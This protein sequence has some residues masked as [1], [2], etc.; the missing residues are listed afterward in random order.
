MDDNIDVVHE[1]EECPKGHNSNLTGIELLR[2]IV[3]DASSI[4]EV[5]DAQ[6]KLSIAFDA[7]K[8]TDK[9]DR[10]DECNKL[11]SI[12]EDKIRA[13]TSGMEKIEDTFEGTII[14]SSIEENTGVVKFKAITGQI[15]TKNKNGRIYEKA[16]WDK[17]IPRIKAMMRRGQ[18][19]GLAGHPGM[20]DAGNPR[21]I[22]VKFTDIEIDG[23]NVIQSGEFVTTEA[24]Q[25]MIALVRAGINLEWSWRGWGIAVPVD[26]E[27]YDKD[28]WDYKG[29]FYIRDYVYDGTD[30]V[31]RGA[32][33]TRTLSTDSQQSPPESREEE[34]NTATESEDTSGEHGDTIQ[35]LGEGQN[36]EESVVVDTASTTDV[37]IPEKEEKPVAPQEETEMT[38]DSENINVEE[39]AETPAPAPAHDV[40]ELVR[41][42]VNA[43]MNAFF[44]DQKR[45]DA[46]AKLEGIDPD[47]ANL[48]KVN[49]ASAKTVEEVDSIVSTVAPKLEAMKNPPQFSGIGVINREKTYREAWFTGSK[50]ADRPRTVQ[51]VKAALLDGLEGEIGDNRSHKHTFNDILTTYENVEGG[52]YLRALTRDGFS[53]FMDTASTTTLLGTAIPHILPMLRKLYPMLISYEI[54]TVIPIS[55]P[56]ARVYTIGHTTAGSSNYWSDSTYFDSTAADHTENNTK[57]QIAPKISETDITVSEKAI[58]FDLTSALIQDAKAQYNLDLESELLSAAAGEIARELN[59]TFL[60]LLRSGATAL[61]QNYGTAKPTGYAN[62]LDWYDMLA[63]FVAKVGGKIAEK[64]YTGANYLVVD[65]VT[66]PLITATRN[67]QQFSVPAEYGAGL[68][69]LG[70]FSSTYTV[71]VAEWFTANTIL[72]IAKGADW[73]RTGA[74]FCPYI[75]LYYSPMDSN[76]SINTIARSVSSRNGQAIV[77]GNF[78]GIVNIQPGTTGEAPF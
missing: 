5:I 47:F 2:N 76:A 63:L 52:K 42:Q 32:A 73:L 7:Y 59:Y 13:I 44:M 70:Q 74:V 17:N 51:E 11:E 64:V 3:T 28:P 12:I 8:D 33:R 58:Y 24:G 25:D 26:Q 4:S 29:G 66:A 67:F 46:Y 50:I 48:L 34:Q 45:N 20:F 43:Q 35:T 14:E 1:G 65:P 60:E 75:P 19:T 69:G 21:D 68:R 39:S 16:E 38:Q 10:I 36:V 72:V 56:T 23:K 15:D 41:E 53:Q 6:D 9:T 37:L 61:S 31:L 18:L 40:T 27:K 55:Q 49:I 62:D 78:Y 22:C 57:L 77:D 54:A 71:F 30:V